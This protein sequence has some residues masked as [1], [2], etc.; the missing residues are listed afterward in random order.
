MSTQVTEGKI[1]FENIV[2]RTVTFHLV[3]SDGETLA[4]AAHRRKGD[5]FIV[6][7]GTLPGCVARRGHTP[8]VIVINEPDGVSVLRAD[9]PLRFFFYDAYGAPV[10]LSADTRIAGFTLP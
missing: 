3:T 8:R 7:T 4:C 2:S 9:Q 6:T 1:S 10:S 5:T